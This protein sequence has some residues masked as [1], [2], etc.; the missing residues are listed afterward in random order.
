LSKGKPLLFFFVVSAMVGKEALKI[1]RP[2]PVVVLGKA[3]GAKK[4]LVSLTD[5][6]GKMYAAK[7]D[8][9]ECAATHHEHCLKV[10]ARHGL[11][12]IHHLGKVVENAA[13]CRQLELTDADKVIIDRC[14]IGKR[15]GAK[16]RIAFLTQSLLLCYGL[17]G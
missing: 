2:D 12:V 13:L 3:D 4:R 5:E 17:Y 9:I 1:D 8:E 16:G 7:V 10:T 6:G 15:V 11:D 14:R